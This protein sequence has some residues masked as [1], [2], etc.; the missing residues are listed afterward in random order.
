MNTIKTILF[1]LFLFSCLSCDSDED[2]CT[3]LPC[4]ELENIKI[5]TEEE[6]NEQC[7]YDNLYMYRGELYT[8][9]VCCV[10][11]LIYMAYGCFNEPLCD[12]SEDCMLDFSEKAVY[13]YSFIAQ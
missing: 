5:L 12:I 7:I 11:D 13:Q 1:S 6:K 4:V 2:V 10:C 8:T 3:I 9:K